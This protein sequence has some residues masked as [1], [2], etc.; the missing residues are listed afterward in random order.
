M[1][2]F[3][4]FVNESRKQLDF[5]THYLRDFVVNSLNIPVPACPELSKGWDQRLRCLSYD[6]QLC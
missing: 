3:N 4:I 6:A 5:R 2:N 1:E